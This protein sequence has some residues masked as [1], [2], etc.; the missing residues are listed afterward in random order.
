M[1]NHGEIY[2]AVNKE[3]PTT[4]LYIGSDLNT[5]WQ[6]H[7]SHSRK[8]N[9]TSL[10][11]EIYEN[12]NLYE[13]PHL[14]YVYYDNKKELLARESNKIKKYKPLANI[15]TNYDQMYD[16]ADTDSDS[17]T[18]SYLYCRDESDGSIWDTDDEKVTA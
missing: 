15:R 3:S 1:A 17:D 16:M 2:K 9:D 7:I 8:H 14:A 13:I 12:A 18:Q 6:N 10:Y 11:K 5:R 4:I